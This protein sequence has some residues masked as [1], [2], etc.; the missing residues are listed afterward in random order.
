M[1][2]TQWA[3]NALLLIW[4]LSR[5]LGVRA[6][7]R[8]MFVVP[9]LIVVMAAGGLLR[10]VPTVG[11]DWLLEA[12]G[13]GAGLV[14]G[15]LA[16]LLC[17]VEARGQRLTVSAGVGFAALW[18]AVIGGR[19]LFATWAE[20]PGAPTIGA[21]SRE[22]LITGADAWTAAF[23]LMALAMV[24]GRLA[25]LAIQLVRFGGTTALA[26]VKS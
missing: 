12:V 4:I 2:T 5:N 13:A 6:V 20:G 26:E 8:S 10:D 25:T 19:M 11:N 3:L 21:F 23:V 16:A 15:V 1:S 24:A 9:L 17:R 18:V 14:L 7:T 22:H